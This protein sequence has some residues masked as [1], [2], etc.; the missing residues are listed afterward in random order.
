MTVE[1]WVVDHIEERVAAIEV[2]GARL[3]HMPLEAL[4]AGVAEG[5]VLRVTRD[6]ARVLIER[7]DEARDAA[8]ARSR[9][10]TTARPDPRDPGGPIR[11]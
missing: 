9:A 6:G 11:L 8:L 3:I 5:D 1:R 7:D 10:Q 4:P 2:G